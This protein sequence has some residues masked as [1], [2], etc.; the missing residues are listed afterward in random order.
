MVLSIAGWIN[1]LTA[2]GLAIYGCVFGYYLIRE[3]RKTDAK[4][5]SIMGVGI[6]FAGFMW[7]GIVFGFF[8]VLLTG[9]NIDNTY[10]IVGIMCFVWVP[11]SFII[12]IYIIAE[13]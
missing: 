3:G 7:L 2:T 5:L 1:G 8:S 6:I 9:R 12:N 13:I 10:G 4:L 11:I